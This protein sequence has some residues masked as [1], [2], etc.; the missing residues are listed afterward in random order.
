LRGARK[1]FKG[2]GDLLKE[3]APFHHGTEGNQRTG[4]DAKNYI[5][6][7][8]DTE[9]RK[10]FAA[11]YREILREGR[12]ARTL[13]GAIYRSPSVTVEDILAAT[14]RAFSGRL[15]YHPETKRFSY[16][17]GQYWPT[18]YRAAACAVL[19]SVLWNWSERPSADDKRTY[20]RREFGRGIQSRWFN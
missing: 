3:A 9:G 15:T 19:A 10:A 16:C 14:K 5:S 6:D 11:E 8:R 7:W 18:E 4:M 1:V 17:V 2:I 20:F 12:D 13:L